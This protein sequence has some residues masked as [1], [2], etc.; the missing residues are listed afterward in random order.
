[1]FNWKLVVLTAVV[2]AAVPTVKL[3]VDSDGLAVVLPLVGAGTWQYND[4]EAYSSVCQAFAAGYSFVDTANG[5]GN[6]RGVGRAVA[7]CWTRPREELFVMTKI[8]GGLNAS[9]T[10]RAHAQNLEQLGL[11][12]VD[13]LMTHYPADWAATPERSSKA[14]RQT[15]WLA[16]EAIYARGEARSIGVSHYCSTHIDDVLEIATVKPTVNQV[17]YHVGSGDVDDVMEKCRANGIYF[18]SYSALCGPC[19]YEPEDSLINGALVSGIAAKHGVSGSQVSLRFVV[20]Q[21]LQPGAYIAGVI[22]KSNNPAHIL[23]NFNLFNFEL[24]GDD[25]AALQAANKPAG[26]PG[27]CDVP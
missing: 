10:E 19:M 1:M 11:T 2:G 14:A 17:E 9:E 15:E 23:S 26:E 25:M 12:F 13:H 4:T 18:M 5:Y 27:D 16:L 7:E 22:P 6:Q 24:D 21:A 3:G 20:Q 8:P